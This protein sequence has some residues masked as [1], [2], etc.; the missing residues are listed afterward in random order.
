MLLRN[1]N[2]AW[3]AGSWGNLHGVD[4]A[5]MIEVVEHL[6]ADVLRY[7]L[8]PSALQSAACDNKDWLQ[9]VLTST[10]SSASVFFW[11]PMSDCYCSILKS[12]C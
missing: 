8:F 5:L 11:S 3:H 2:R 6:D 4:M 1:I 12:P 7:M 10:C 9:A